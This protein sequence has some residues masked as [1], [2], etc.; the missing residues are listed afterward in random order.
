MVWWKRNLTTPL[1]NLCS[2]YTE[3]YGVSL[4]TK[5]RITIW[6]TISLLSIYPEKTMTQKDTCIPMSTAALN[7]IAKTWKQTKCVSTDE[8]IKKMWYIH[9]HKKERNL[10]AFA[11]TWMDLEII[12]LSEVRQW[13]TNIICYYF[14]VDLKKGFKWTYLQNRNWLTDFEKLMVNKGDRLE[15]EGWAGV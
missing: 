15:G 1:V 7:A 3:Q 10:M 8:W 6:S 4:K 9:S 11:A 2:H 5:N 13:D 14:Y 12:M